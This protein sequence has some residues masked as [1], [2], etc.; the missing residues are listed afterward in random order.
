MLLRCQYV[1]G[2]KSPSIV[3]FE[4]YKRVLTRQLGAVETVLLN[5]ARHFAVGEIAGSG[6]KRWNE[7]EFEAKCKGIQKS[8]RLPSPLPQTQYL[9]VGAR[10]NTVAGGED[11]T[12]K[13]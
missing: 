4:G 12:G 9:Q 10:R 11:R 1:Q 13:T 3:S 7:H 2:V 5:N 6:R 8:E